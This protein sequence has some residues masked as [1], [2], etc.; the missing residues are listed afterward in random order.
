MDRLTFFNLSIESGQCSSDLFKLCIQ[1]LVSRLHGV[2]GVPKSANLL[3]MCCSGHEA[4]FLESSGGD[5]IVLYLHIV[6]FQLCDASFQVFDREKDVL[7]V[8]I[9]WCRVQGSLCHSSGRGSPVLSVIDWSIFTEVRG[10]CRC[11]RHGVKESRRCLSV[12][13]EAETVKGET[14]RKTIEKSNRQ[15]GA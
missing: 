2:Y 9:I 5:S 4:K 1:T 7:H 11:G 15:G 13:I 10:F 8:H 3:I 12:L 6:L 14:N